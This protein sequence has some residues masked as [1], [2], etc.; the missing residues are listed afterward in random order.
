MAKWARGAN[1]KCT[2]NEARG[3][4]RVAAGKRSSVK[5]TT[6]HRD[7]DRPIA[8]SASDAQEATVASS[9]PRAAASG[10]GRPTPSVE[11][12]AGAPEVEGVPAEAAEAPAEAA[13]VERNNRVAERIARLWESTLGLKSMRSNERGDY[14]DAVAMLRDEGDMLMSFCEGTAVE[15]NVRRNLQAAEQKMASP[16]D[17]RSKR[18]SMVAAKKF[19]K[20]ERDHRSDPKG[21]WS[22]HL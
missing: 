20:G 9:E 17:G 13:A 11:T 12:V 5:D 6:E 21:D 15:R 22:D 10:N 2:G 19:S 8:D 16:W 18:E 1:N 4:A 7:D 3:H 14:V